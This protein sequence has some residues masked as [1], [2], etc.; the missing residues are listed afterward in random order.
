MGAACGKSTVRADEII[1][2]RGERDGGRRGRARERA[3]G[4]GSSA[5]T[6][7]VGRGSKESLLGFVHTSVGRVSREAVVD[8]WLSADAS[9]CV[10]EKAVGRTISA[11]TQ[12]RSALTDVRAVEL[13]ECWN[14]LTC[15]RCVT[16]ECVPPRSRGGGCVCN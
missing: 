15:A 6:S 2:L 13:A 11:A 14:A 12:R 3:D 5:W 7:N 4:A 16:T 8:T 1:A 10:R 9:A